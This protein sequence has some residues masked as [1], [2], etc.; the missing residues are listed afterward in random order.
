MEKVHNVQV[1][2]L[3]NEMIALGMD[4]DGSRNELVNRLNQ[5]GIYEIDVTK[6]TSV[7]MLKMHHDPTCVSI[8]SKCEQH[9]NCLSIAN[10]QHTLISGDFKNRSVKIH[11][12]LQLE[13]TPDLNSDTPGNVGDIRICNGDLYVY[14]IANGVDGWYPIQFGR[15]IIF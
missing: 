4:S 15:M 10:N 14:R 9:N 2:R 11:D 7:P 6:K 8:G 3:R 12:C 1:S 13:N 5:A